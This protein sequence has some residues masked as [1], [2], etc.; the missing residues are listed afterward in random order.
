MVDNNQ[1]QE[2]PQDFELIELLFG[3]VD[4]STSSA[5]DQL[6]LSFEARYQ[7]LVDQ[8]QSYLH[9]S[10]KPG[11][12]PHRFLGW[13]SSVLD[14]K[15]N[16]KLGIKKLHFRFEGARTLKVVAETENKTHVFIFTEDTEAQH[17]NS[18]QTRTKNF[19][20]TTG[21][22]KDVMGRDYTELDARKLQIDVIKILKDKYELIKSRPKSDKD[23]KSKKLYLYLKNNVL[24]CKAK[25][26]YGNTQ[27]MQIDPDE[28]K[29]HYLPQDEFLKKA[30][31]F[32][33]SSD[34]N[35]SDDFSKEISRIVSAKGYT[36][37]S[38]GEDEKINIKVESKKKIVDQPIEPTVK[39][40]EVTKKLGK[41]IYLEDY[42]EKLV[43]SDTRQA[44][45][46]LEDILNYIKK[47]HTNLDLQGNVYGIKAREA[48]QHGF[49]AGIFDNFRYRDNTKLYLEQFAGGGYADIVLLVRGP[50]RAVDSVPIL[51]ELKAGTEGQVD[52][53]DALRQAEDYIKGFR[54]NKMRILTNAGDAI[55]VG[56]NLDNAEPFKTEV[57][58]IKR[59][60]APLMEEFIELVGK[61]N[62]KSAY[63]EVFKREVKDLLSSEYHTFP[64]NKETKDHY[65]FSRDI[66]GQSILINKIGQ[67]QSNIKKYIYSYDEYPLNWPQ[68]TEYTL[69]KSPVMTL[70]FVQGNEGQEKT[71]FIFHI[72]E[73][74]TKE[75]YADK[76]IPV[77]NIPGIGRVGN[78]IEIKMSL[79]KYETGLSFEDL[80]EIEQISK[81]KPSGA[82]QQFAGSFLKIPN[83]DELKA[84]FDQAITS[85]HTTS[86]DGEVSLQA[87][88]GLL[89]EVADAI[90]PIKDL[91]TNEAR[92]QAVLN[93]LFSS[94][95]DLK[96]QETSSKTVI[97]PEFQVGAGGRVDMVIQGIGPS[98]QGTKEYTPIALE[99]K[100]I[101][102][103][104]NQNQLKQEVDKLT[105][106]QNIR[107]AKGAAL[108]AITDSDKMLFMGVVV[109]AKAKD[110]GSLILTSDEFVPALVVHSSIDIAKRKHLEGIQEVTQRLK[111]I[112]IQEEN[113]NTLE[114]ATAE[115]DYHYWLQQH[116]IAD[117]ARI[118]YGYGTDGANTLFEVVGSPKHIANQLQQFQNSVA[119]RGEK[120]PLTL[121]VNLN[122]NH[123]VTL[124]VAYQNGKYNGYYAD[125]FGSN[126]P[127]S[128]RQVLQQAQITVNDVSFAQQRDGHNCGLWALENARDINDVLQI[129]RS[130]NIPNEIRNRLQV[131]GRNEDYF[132]RAREDISDRLS[133]DSQRIANL[134]TILAETQQPSKKFNLNSCVGGGSRR[135]RSTNLCL[136]SKGDVEKFSKGR[137][138]E[139]DIDKII[140]DSEKFLT[141]VK[142]SQDEK[143]NAQLV[144]FVEDK[145]I[146]GNHKYLLDKVIGDQGY[147]RYVQ[148]ERIKGLH[149]DVSQQNSGL[150]KNP[151]LKSRL[152]NAAG[153]IQLIRGIHGAIVSCK[154]GTATDCGLNLGGIGWSFASQPIENVMVKIT[155]K[156]VASAE[157][158]VGKIPGV[159][160]KRTK[161]A[162]RV[163]GVKFGSTIAKGAAGAI[164][165]VFD[166]VE[167]G[168]STSNLVDCKKRENSD[169]PCGEKEIRDNIASIAFSSTSFVSGVALTALNMPV[170]GI[171]AGAALMVGYGIYSG[172]SNIVEYKKKYDTT[173]GENW[174][175]F[176]RTIL[177]QDMAS[178][179]Q[180]LAD[181]KNTV[182]S[183]AKEVWKALNNAPN[184]VVAYGVGLGKVSD[185]TLRPD[186]AKILMD[187]EDT[188]TKDLSRVIPDR[189]P[190]ASRIC[191]PKVTGQDYEKGITSS[192]QPPL[193]YCENAMVISH[194]GR[195]GKTIVYDLRNI[196]KG[197]IV[198]SNK[199]N[200]NFLIYPGTTKI[201]GGNNVANRFVL[202]NNPSFSG[203]IIGGSNSTNILDLSQLTKDKVSIR[204]NYRFKPSAHGQLKVEINNRLLI[205]DYVG[206]NLFNYHYIG[207]K[208]KVDEVLCMG[209]SEHFTGTDDR[210]VIIDSGGGSN[211]NEKDVVE[212]C[213]KVIISPYTTVKGGKS[214]Y[215]FYVKTADY[216]GRGL[217][218][219]IDV[220]GTGTVVFPEIDLLSDCD[221][222]TYSTNSNTLS[223]KINLGQNNQF[224]LDIKNYAEQSSNKPYFVLIDK[225]GSNIVPKIEKSDSSAIK[226]NSFELHSEYP[227]DNFDNVETHYKK[228]LNN[229][230]DY[231]VLSVVRSKTESQDNNMVPHMVFGSSGDDVINFDQGT[232]FARGGEGSDVYFISNDINSREVKIDNNSNDK[233]LDILFM[234]EV[235]K[236]FSIQQCDLHLNY[237]DTDIQVKNYLQD[238]NYRHLIVMNKKGETFIPYVQSMSCSSSEKGKLV[239]FLQATQ[240]QN[241]FLLPKDFQG[242]HV[243]IDSRLEDIK[244]Y[245]DKDDLLLIRES[246]IPFMIRI[247]GFYTNRSKWEDIS[248]SLWN[249][250]DLVPSSDLLEN[251]DNV[252]EYK[253]KLRSDYE[254]IVKEYIMDFSNPTTVIQHNQKSEKG[255][256][257]FIGEDEE[258]IGVMILKNTSPDQVEVFSSGTDLIFRD[259]K[260][261]HTIDIKDWDNSESYRISILEFDLGLEPITI[262]RLDRFSLSEVGKV[263]YLIGKASENCQNRDK[264]TPKVEN[265]FKCLVS[266]DN[267]TR[268]NKSPAYRC[269]GFSSLQEQVSFTENFC[270]LEGIEELKGKMTSSSQILTL[271]EKL[272]NNLL[273]NGYDSNTIDQCSKWMITSGLGVL[274]PLVSTAVYEGKWDEVKTLLDKTAKKSNVDIEHKN[275]CS[276]N[277]TSLH[278]AV[279][280]GNVK[281]S[282]S[283]FKSFLEKKGDINALTSCNDDNWALLHYAVYYGNLD[284]VSFLIDKG[285][286]IEIRSKEGKTP[287]HLA[288]EEAKQNMIN[289]LLD[290]G[291]DIEAKNNDGRTPLYL[292]AYNNDSGVIELL[293]NRIKTKSNDAFKMIKQVEFLKKEVV[294]QANIPSNAKGLVES[295]ISSLRGS[296]KS[297][298]ERV[299]KDGMLNNRNASTIELLDEVYNFDEK[300]FGGAIKEAV[301]D[302]YSQVDK[303]EILRF[304]YSHNSPDQSISGYIAV[305]DKM[306]KN[307]GALFELARCI[308]NTVDSS[309][310]SSVRSEKRSD[311]EKLKSRLPESVR[312]AVFSSK[313]CIK[314]VK[315]DE[316]LYAA[317][318][319]PYDGYRRSVFTWHTK[320][321]AGGQ[322]QWKIE[323]DG[324]NYHI[325]NVQYG[326]Y[327]YAADSYKYDDYRRYVFTWHTKRRAG[328]Q[329]QWKIEL[330]GDNCHIKNVQYDEYLYAADSYKYDSYR[331]YVF[332]WH[333][334]DRVGDQSR[335]KIEDCGS[336][337]NR[338]SLQESNG[339]NQTVVDYKSIL[340]E[341]DDRQI[342]SRISAIVEDIER[343]TFLNQSKNKLDLDS[344]LNNRG[345]SN[346]DLY[347]NFVKEDVCSELNTS[348]RKNVILGGNDICAITS[349][350]ETLDIENFPIQ[351]VVVNDDINGKK[352]LRRTLDLH[353]LMQQ[354]DR[355]LSIKPI[356]TVMKD[357]D[358]LLIKLSISATGLQQDVITVRLKDALINKWY[359][360]LQIIFDNA[361]VEIDDNLDLKSSFFI[362]DEN[363][364]EVT[365]QSIEEKNKLIV[366]KKAGQYTYLHDKYDLIVTNVFNADVEASELCIIRFKDFYKEPKMETLSI[367]F[368]DREILLSNEIDKIRNSDS[369]DELNNVSSIINS[370]KNSIPLES[371]NSGDINAQGKLGRTSLHL[372]SG[373]GEFDKVKLLLDRGAN[374]K[375]QDK[376]GYTPIFLAT[377]SGKWSIVKLLLDR[378]ANIDAQDKEGKTLLHFAASGNNL[379]MVQFLLDRGANIEVQDRRA[380]TPTLYA[381]QSGKWGVVKLL[382]SNGAKFNNE[383]TYQGTPLHFAA[384]EGNLDMVR[385]LLDEGAEIESQDKDNKK[386]LHLAVEAGR[387]SVVK[388]L[389]DRGAS[390]NVIDMNSQTP[391]GLA[392]KGDMIEIL[393][394]AELDQG[395][396]INARGGNLDKVKD[397][398][399]QGANLETKDKDGKI[400]LELAE[401][402]GY[403]DIVEILKQTQLNLD[404][405]LLIAIEKED[406][407]KV[408]D[409]IRRGANVNAQSRLGWISVFWA[410]QKNNLSIVK[411]LVNNGADINAKDN[412]SWM[413]LHWAVQL[414]SLDVVKYLVERGANVNAL[415]ADGRTPL[416]LAAQKNRVNV[417]EFLKKAQLDLDKEL[418]T[419]VQDGDLNKV[420]GLA[421]QGAG[422]NTKGSNDW[423]LLHFAA[424]SNKFD[425]VKFLLDKNANIKAKDVYG[426][427]P[428][429]VAAQY[430]SKLEIVEFLLD[431][432]ASGINDVNN[433]GSTPL[434]VAIQGNKSSTVK[435]LLNKGASIQVKD[436]DG[437]TPLDLAKQEGYTNIVQM[438]EQRQSD[439]DE[440]LLTAVRDGNLNEV[441]DLVSQNANVNTRDIYSW[442]P[443]H[444]ATFKDHLEIARFL[445]K[446]GADINA[447]DKGPY[448]KKSIHVAAE[449]NSKDII[450]FFLSKGVGINDTDKQGYTPLHYAAWRGR[451]E[452][453]KFLIEKGADMNAADTSTAGKKP[454]HVAAENNN[455]DIIEF[456]LSKGVSVDAAD[457]NGWT[458]LHYAASKD[459]LEVA[460]FLIEKGADINAENMYGKKPIQRAAENNS[461]N[462]VELL[463]SKGVSVNDADKNGWTPLHWASW[464]GHLDLV[465][466]FIDK[467]ANINTKGKDS[468]ISLDVATD[469]KHNDVVGYLKKAQLGEQLLTVVQ[470]GNLKEVKDLVSQGAILN[471]QDR[472][473][474]TPL[475]FAVSSNRLDIVRYLIENGANINAKDK[476]GKTPL[477]WASS[478]GKL[479]IAKYL[480]GKGANIDA[481]DDG[482]RVPLNEAGSY[483]NMERVLMQAHLDRELLLTVKSEKDLKTIN[484]L[485]AKDID[486]RTH[487]V[488]YYTWSGNLG[489]VEFLVSKDV[490]VNATDKYGCTLL[491]WAALKGHSDITK[492]LV[493]KGAN[494]NAKDILGRI[495]MHFA[496]MNNNVNITGFL[497]NKGANVD[498]ADKNGWTPL[499]WAALEDCL[500]VAKFLVDKGADVNAKDIYGKTP[501]DIARDK[502]Y[503]NIMKRLEK[504]INEKREKP[505]QRK[506]RHHHIDSSNQPEIAASSGT[507]PS[508]WIND[509]ISWVKSSVGGLFYSGAALPEET[510]NTTSAISQVDAPMDVNGT[511]MLLDVLVR[512]VT[513]QKYISTVDQ[514]ISPLEAQGYTLNITKGFEKVVEQAAKGSKISMHR[515]NI[516]FMEMG[517]EIT[518]K[519]IGGKFDEISGILNSYVEKACPG[520]E[521]GCPGKL[522]PK[523][524]DK[525]MIQFN[526]R[527]NIVLNQSVEQILHNRDGKLEVDGAKKQQMILEPQ[528]HLSNASVHSHSKVSTCLSDVGVTKL[529][530]NLNR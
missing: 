194:D 145:S 2:K 279:Y 163:V 114:S 65:Y 67:D 235:G 273:L 447:A 503:N 494:V 33:N 195:N 525:F 102:K 264:Y 460:K 292:A 510:L 233:K 301:S 410:I 339:Y 408:K 483:S 282:E 11:F 87:Y 61:W 325:K 455:R 514:P 334:Q 78:V 168:M 300:L 396:L 318:Y 482:G 80:F 356:P 417:I 335:W 234:P 99:F 212:N 495:P 299:L 519:I 52:P 40:Q 275:Q 205:D 370:Q 45:E 523:K 432:N 128:I 192:V 66:L 397:L 437:K 349:G 239:P 347:P 262:R 479:D 123:W 350:H 452:V 49:V 364:I 366:S 375:V 271:L 355:D 310:Y 421:N 296:I 267:F 170:V 89:T 249:N 185:N 406:L 140:I 457:N 429:H 287:L 451:L 326:E 386:P 108:K 345:R 502:G 309:K 380:W 183:L 504:E 129:S 317:S 119:T 139:N 268:E 327:L 419:A 12:F 165:G 177:F 60:P 475:Y 398:I 342:A 81:Y 369:I 18:P 446:K 471:A 521:A 491:H 85:Q 94:Y 131:Q 256:S 50:N 340:T 150:I 107:Y 115:K 353:Q 112:G 306:P 316:Y 387:L 203:K 171:A 20:F 217:Y 412:E 424:S 337:R 187:K 331:R 27:T 453:A 210:D 517:K 522:S 511:I 4:S 225:N 297:E 293:C 176:W 82:D 498:E 36:L 211:N 238:S 220:D 435:F 319:A 288:V 55:A 141:Y 290:R 22:W 180:H 207:R 151:K 96:L 322:S 30:K 226:I 184:S 156:V 291:A 486:D 91:I 7:S 228:I 422:L 433:N 474:W 32:L 56:L 162:V 388:L 201:T 230:K 480:I 73:S 243:V 395:L 450:E 391:L 190:G 312:N 526:S 430:D 93:G 415:T 315:Y 385:F 438:I 138:D 197:E 126:V 240:T 383:I 260:S 343:H 154:D 29:G 74:N 425:I 157:K 289:L 468:K 149:G 34:K 392:T 426:N 371:P 302:V 401:Q 8:I 70:I 214:N 512:K 487:G 179:V 285:A 348:E 160:G 134:E 509:C 199:W 442:T 35:L 411:L 467:G 3:K 231:K 284:M 377:Q 167:I 338:R 46:N 244:K 158:V 245:K 159:L 465:K 120:R 15:L 528:S 53:S 218:S 132:I 76:K 400:P 122:N 175:I 423:T 265:D 488:F 72:R 104:L 508:S 232:M 524:F 200:N 443:L 259:K 473:G 294:N 409:N 445:M 527:L 414:G 54:P 365:S 222:I 25:D 354:V 24:E 389:L 516:D 251:V 109:N 378:G 216:K 41:S 144:E 404:R 381:A 258:R 189:I 173:H 257:T 155:P 191:L 472:Y 253:D 213:K 161:F 106:E 101:D 351:E 493:D 394:K 272:E 270:S 178:D 202:V 390:V 242:D 485:I 501:L 13:F 88:K 137:V 5:V 307:D 181:R 255:I 43:S 489:I 38:D 135:K 247:E 86:P 403:T 136:F 520:R 305:F 263:Q 308:K 332:T 476:E 373:A 478:N 314:N 250:N 405:E 295:C 97:I 320:G 28:L 330:D 500:E 9:S 77:L 58:P 19:E 47:I 277:W 358:D 252:T 505:A 382:V 281:L 329:S 280:N 223:L 59:P 402:K 227:L 172:V 420:E 261:N 376:F 166:I 352:S 16:D 71:A 146:E 42:I 241:M 344:Y 304:I 37:K 209:Y 440:E 75:F 459:C 283:V 10:E 186:Y 90:Y 14:T 23:V 444:W 276:Q 111:D 117:I 530:G 79:K 384:Q 26:V 254:R 393:K 153:G 118:E 481:K 515:L 368:A 44:K 147:E 359:K 116:D 466:Y 133:I 143:K 464:G 110:K 215:T 513:G 372:A 431:K 1:H 328:G 236:D 204:V 436:K 95:S 196:D 399:A 206:N 224:T 127:D 456:L 336:T 237:N 407:G 64:A 125:S 463:L 221:Q 17:S 182:D 248:Y 507:R 208:N 492:F 360:K 321:Q 130:R 497:L 219:E 439:L 303:K 341:E 193:Y 374:I 357:K 229:N 324:S 449:N 496:I 490:S 529:G 379:D 148:N 458:P 462:I 454:I 477:H 274:K 367:K 103:N 39:F 269:L 362:S 506:R 434:H 121:I 174:S 499:H 169:N 69:S 427:T 83:S 470:V 246:E 416:D 313:V 198:G 113:L 92:L 461:K 311:L 31:Q 323:L 164:A 21:E 57:K 68:G 518:G 105:K 413:P 441:E 48:D 6:D 142:N 152:M 361:P 484:D 278:Y 188:N 418:L 84:K 63:E 298:A 469:Q 448:G 286:K 62:N 333:T 98:P 124:V 100:L 51:I 266:A 346:A 363:F 428:L